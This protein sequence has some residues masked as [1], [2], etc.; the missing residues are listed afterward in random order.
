MT[1]WI[2]FTDAK[3]SY[4]DL[5]D[6]AGRGDFILQ[7][8]MHFSV[9]MWSAL[10]EGRL[11]ARTRRPEMFRLSFRSHREQ[12]EFAT[13]S[14]GVIPQIFWT[15]WQQ[16]WDF[17][18]QQAPLARNDENTFS[19]FDDTF[20]FRLSVGLK[21]GGVVEGHAENVQL[22]RR[23]IA[24]LPKPRGHPPGDRCND[25]ALLDKMEGIIAREGCGIRTAAGKVKKQAKGSSEEAIVDR[26]R[27]KFTKRRKAR[28]LD[29]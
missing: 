5:Q 26:L 22:L 24:L 29:F 16:T 28:K 15:F 8:A 11:K 10:Q 20:A 3:E 27:R 17:V 6:N 19:S 13:P 23:E 25:E 1:Q 12:R 2:G 7:D 9:C 4:L 21:D 14:D 18:G